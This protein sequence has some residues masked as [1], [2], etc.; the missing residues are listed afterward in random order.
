MGGRPWAHEAARGAAVCHPRPRCGRSEGHQKVPACHRR[1]WE[2]LKGIPTPL[3]PSERSPSRSRRRAV[4]QNE[5]RTIKALVQNTVCPS[6]LSPLPRAGGGGAQTS[7]WSGGAPASSSVRKGNERVAAA[8]GCIGFPSSGGRRKLVGSGERLQEQ[9]RSS[10]PSP[11]LR[12]GSRGL[13]GGFRVPLSFPSLRSPCEVC[14]A[15]VRLRPRAG[16][17]RGVAGAGAAQSSR[18]QLGWR[19]PTG[20]GEM[21]TAAEGQGS[22]AARWV[23]PNSPRPCGVGVRS[24]KEQR[25]GTNPRGA[26]KCF[27]RP[28]R[29]QS[30][31]ARFC[32]SCRLVGA[33]GRTDG[34]TGLS[35][36]RTASAARSRVSLK[37]MR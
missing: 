4:K 35:S 18:P 11:P 16:G 34:R 2:R 33:D 29:G 14:S 27:H 26:A 20:G 25:W 32:P 3:D 22:S 31:H 17:A 19:C 7:L 13:L 37:A 21:E 6:P 1:G 9:L 15:G 36:H 8:R 10:A 28:A 24:S 30:G 5:A 23:L 12:H